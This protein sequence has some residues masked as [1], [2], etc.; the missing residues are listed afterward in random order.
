MKSVNLFEMIEADAAKS[1][2]SQREYQSGMWFYLRRKQALIPKLSKELN[3]RP[4]W[5]EVYYAIFDRLYKGIAVSAY[6]THDKNIHY[7]I[8]R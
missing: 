3:C 8:A 2:L 5:Y 6:D 1:E 4:V 7:P